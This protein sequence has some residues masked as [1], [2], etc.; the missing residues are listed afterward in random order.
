ML[1]ERKRGS[2]GSAS[3][4]E[5]DLDDVS[6]HAAT[7]EAMEEEDDEETRTMTNSNKN[8]KNKQQLYVSVVMMA[9]SS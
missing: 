1:D 7:L 5:D 6:D 8:N 3:T 4:K 9:S 2:K